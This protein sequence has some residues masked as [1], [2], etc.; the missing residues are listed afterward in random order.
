MKTIYLKVDVP[1]GY[2]ITHKTVEIHNPTIPYLGAIQYPEFTQIQLPT[3]E[4]IVEKAMNFKNPGDCILCM[5]WL[6]NKIKS[7]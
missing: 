6:I 7:Q 1:D 2:Y 3:E 4:E 5:E